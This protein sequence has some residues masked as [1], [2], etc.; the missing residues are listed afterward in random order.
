MFEGKPCSRYGHT[1]RYKSNHACVECE[2]LSYR[3]P[4]HQAKAKE[5]QARHRANPH[6]TIRLR[7]L[8]RRFGLTV[9]EFVAEETRQGN[10]CAICRNPPSG[11]WDRLH[12]DH[13]HVPG[14][15]DMPPEEKR[16]YFR[17]LL[18]FDCNSGLGSFADS[19]DRLMAA[20]VYLRGAPAI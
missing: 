20:L 9:E 10:L 2:Q 17:G 15:D 7:Y 1:L 12:V 16:K 14:Y 3:D 11:R 19:S 13:E 5:A 18:C 4:V 6:N 8:W